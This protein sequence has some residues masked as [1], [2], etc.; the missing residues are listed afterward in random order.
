MEEDLLAQG[1]GWEWSKSSR[2][3]TGIHGASKVQEVFLRRGGRERAGVAAGMEEEVGAHLYV[4]AGL[5]TM[6]S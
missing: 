6:G 4:L 3:S 2:S 1:H 5:E